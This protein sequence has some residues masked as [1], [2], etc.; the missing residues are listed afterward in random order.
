MT[1]RRDKITTPRTHQVTLVRAEGG[2][3]SEADAAVRYVN[4][5]SF[6]LERFRSGTDIN[7]AHADGLAE[8]ARE[9]CA[10]TVTV[11]RPKPLTT[12]AARRTTNKCL[13]VDR[14]ESDPTSKRV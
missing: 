5:Q 8:V 9:L 3:G 13:K 14:M 2:V 7:E 12:G 4:I 1:Y 11:L 10:V 6:P